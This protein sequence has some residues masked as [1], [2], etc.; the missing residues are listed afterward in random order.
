MDRDSALVGE[1]LGLDVLESGLESALQAVV[2][3]GDL[4]SA[5]GF[6]HGIDA[7]RGVGFAAQAESIVKEVIGAFG[8]IRTEG[9]GQADGREDL[10]DLGEGTLLGEEG[11]GKSGPVLK[12]GISE[13]GDEEE[14][15]ISLMLTE[16]LIYLQTRSVGFLAFGVEDA[17]I[18]SIDA[19]QKPGETW[20]DL[21]VIDVKQRGL[22]QDIFKLFGMAGRE[23]QV[24]DSKARSHIEFQTFVLFGRKIAFGVIDAVEMDGRVR[25]M[26]EKDIDGS[27]TI[28]IRVIS[29]GILVGFTKKSSGE[30]HP[31]P[32]ALAGKEKRK[33]PREAEIAAS[34]TRTHLRIKPALEN[35]ECG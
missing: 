31:N 34:M 26:V 10:S 4:G 3:L 23:I 27:E 29:D 35:D 17:G 12:L 28:A 19:L 11:V 15:K 20:P 1:D 2:D 7:A 14:G 18:V 30:V 21:M 6:D 13:E 16:E 9:P 5:K 25:K 22:A 33:R 32:L 24:Q 8:A